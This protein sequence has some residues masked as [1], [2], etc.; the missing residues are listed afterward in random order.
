[1]P[2]KQG[3]EYSAKGKKMKKGLR[4]SEAKAEKESETELLQRKYNDSDEIMRQKIKRM[5]R[6]IH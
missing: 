5:L 4:K 3:L 6:K 1:M 2:V